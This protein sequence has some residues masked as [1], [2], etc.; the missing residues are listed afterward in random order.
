MQ[1]DYLTGI[2]RDSSS[3]TFY[4]AD[5][6]NHRIVSYPSGNIAA[7]GTFGFANNQLSRPT[8]LFYDS[9]SKSF[10]ISNYLSHNVVQWPLGAS[11]WTHM[12]GGING[13]SGNTSTLLLNPIGVIVDPMGN[14]YVADINNYRIQFFSQGQ[15]EGQT[16]AGVTG[17]SSSTAPYLRSPRF[18]A[19]D[20]Q[21]NLYISEI[22]SNRIL[23]FLRY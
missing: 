15:K 18:L 5:S 6:Y 11:S 3:N 14:L 12:A 1:L 4:I 10:I 13:S 17:I 8:G 23:K 9:F 20:N 7:G 21:L 19:L 22:N 2:V 16:I